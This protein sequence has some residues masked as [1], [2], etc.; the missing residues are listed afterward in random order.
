MGNDLRQLSAKDLSILNNPAIIALNQDPLGKSVVRVQ[1]NKHVKK[2]KY[3]IGET[4][5]WSG[6]LFGGDQAVILVNA[7]DEDVEISV[8]LDEIFVF[9]GPGGSAP[10][11]QQE[12]EL[13][14]LWADRMDEKLAEQILDADVETAR[15]LLNKANWYNSTAIPYKDGLKHGDDRLFGRKVGTVQAKGQLTKKVRKHAA[16][17]YRLKAVGEGAKRKEQHHQTEL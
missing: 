9:D 3:G 6:S 16:E 10:Q 12:W 17:V 7:A 8:G 15:K 13:Y 4:Q 14:D 5:V 11:V 1:R 2:D